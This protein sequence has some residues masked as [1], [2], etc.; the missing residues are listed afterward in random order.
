MQ[1]IVQPVA[2]I[3]MLVLHRLYLRDHA[4]A[5][6]AMFSGYVVGFLCLIAATLGAL[7]AGAYFFFLPLLG[8]SVLWGFVVSRALGSL[9]QVRTAPQER[10]SQE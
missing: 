7:L 3:G 6:W 9:R 10:E 5:G 1:W 4:W 2:V 8:V